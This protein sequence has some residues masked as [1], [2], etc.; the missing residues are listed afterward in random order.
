MQRGRHSGK[1]PPMLLISFGLLVFQFVF[2][3]ET[4]F[5]GGPTAQHMP[6]LGL[7]YRETFSITNIHFVER[8]PFALIKFSGK[9]LYYCVLRYGCMTIQVILNKL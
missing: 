3:V 6:S 1:I 4:S 9:I 8:N 7:T 5:Q 2:T